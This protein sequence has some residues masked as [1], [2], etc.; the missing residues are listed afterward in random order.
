MAFLLGAGPPAVLAATNRVLGGIGGI[1][2]GT[3]TGGDG[4]GAAAFTINSAPGGAAVESLIA[5]INPG[6]VIISAHTRFTAT[7]QASIT[8]GNSGVDQVTITIPAAYTNIIPGAVF[9]NSTVVPAG[10]CPVPGGGTQC[11]QLSGS[12]LT[13]TFADR[14]IADANIRIDFSADPPVTAGTS[15]FSITVGD[16]VTVAP[17]VSAAFGDADVLPANNNSLDVTTSSGLDPFRSTLTALPIT[18]VADGLS[19]STVSATLFDIAG[20]PLTG[21]TVTL[22]SDRGGIDTITQPGVTDISGIA[23]GSIT[24]LSPG[25]TT[26]TATGGGILLNQRATVYFTQG[27]VMDVRKSANKEKVQIG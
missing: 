8:A 9:V 24:S 14:I 11:T 7:V 1:N 3:I 25:V 20:L 23:N 15:T 18:V 27:L 5:E 6:T 12:I 26:L 2:N 22:A 13:I 19:A 10:A 16:T 17:P 4:T 21:E